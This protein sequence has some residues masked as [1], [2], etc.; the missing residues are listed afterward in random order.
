MANERGNGKTKKIVVGVATVV[1]IAAI[2]VPTALTLAGGKDNAGA[3]NEANNKY[4]IIVCTGLENVP[5]YSIT[6]NKGTKVSELKT[7]LKAIDGYTIIGIYKDEALSQEYGED[8]IITSD[9]KIYIGFESV[10]YK[11]NIYQEDGITLVRTEEVSYKESLTLDTPTKVEDN[12]ATY[13]FKYWLNER[14]EQVNLDEIISDLNI[15]PYFETHMKEYKIGFTNS[16]NTDSISVTIGGEEVTLRD[17][18]HY[19]STIKLRATAKLGNEITEFKVT[20]NGITTDVLTYANR[21]EENGE[22]Y[23]EIELIGNGDLTITYTEDLKEYTL[24]IPERVTVKRE[25][26]TLESGAT[27]KYGDELEITYTESEGHHKTDFRL[28][29]AE[30]MT[31]DLWK[32]TGDLNIIY[33]EEVN[34]YS[35]GTIP[36]GVTVTR[37]SEDLSSNSKI[38]YGDQLT[39][40]YTETSNRYTGNT[41]QEAGYN[42]LEKEITTYALMVNN[43]ATKSGARIS[44]SDNIT[45]EI[46][47]STSHSWEQGERIEYTIGTIPE[48][49]TVIRDGQELVSFDNIYYGEKLTITY[50]LYEDYSLNDFNINGAIQESENL[51]SVKGDISISFSKT[52]AY[53]YLSFSEYDD[54]YNVSAF[55]NTVSKVFIPATYHGK[56]VIGIESNVFY[57]SNITEVIISNGVE[58]IGAGAFVQCDY[59]ISITIPASLK[60]IGTSAFLNIGGIETIVTIDSA[61]IL[62]VAIDGNITSAGALLMNAKEVRVLSEIDKSENEYLNSNYIMSS[63]DN[64]NVYKKIVVVNGIKFKQ[65]DSGYEAIG[66]SDTSLTSLNIPDEISGIPVVRIGDSAFRE[67]SKITS[68]KFSNN[69]KSIG[70]Q[71]FLAC[72]GLTEIDFPESLT[73]I[74]YGCF[75]GATN[76]K[77]VRYSKNLI[78][79]GDMNF[80]GAQIEKI[81][82]E[83]PTIYESM[84]E[85]GGNVGIYHIA[86]PDYDRYITNIY[87]PYS[88]VE[89]SKYNG[90]FLTKSEK[91]AAYSEENYYVFT[92]YQNI[93]SGLMFDGS[94]ITCFLGYGSSIEVIVPSIYQGKRVSVNFNSNTGAIHSLIL[95]RGVS[96]KSGGLENVT[97]I[98]SLTLYGNVIFEDKWNFSNHK[99]LTTLICG[100]YQSYKNCKEAD[101][102]LSYLYNIISEIRV[103]K[104]IDDGSNI[105]LHTTN[106]IEDGEYWIYP[107]N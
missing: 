82:V 23:Y 3:S 101:V 32:V 95:S 5:D 22:V 42:Y 19:G 69:L 24:I 43:S 93:N 27:I 96:I 34:E 89:D 102:S 16:N 28:E 91:F 77:S 15:H 6:V 7:M 48:G 92:D 21:I 26:K 40:T 57:K 105:N 30:H 75:A 78:S 29:W 20:V 79:I 52:Y 90:H 83:S 106:R 37:G 66:L 33:A 38:Y 53:S 103:L 84:M 36:E 39:F 10:T 61:E 86:G 68:I 72:Y 8:E 35:L 70:R 99:S 41:K 17:T 47:S 80:V 74:E 64:Y 100:D 49:V 50:Y 25:G 12:F 18:Y 81:V 9:T 55:D 62:S 54:G 58:S 104:T 88:I 63:I 59:L 14:N 71:A 94:T 60:T 46:T 1:A 85:N 98:K 4:N 67:N 56:K 73:T 45:L 76:V 11:I 51:Y 107:Q 31:G 65:I 87:V 44:V 13:E 97:S 2:A